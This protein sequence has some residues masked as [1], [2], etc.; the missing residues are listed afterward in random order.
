MY[1]HALRV[2]LPGGRIFACLPDWDAKHAVGVL[3]EVMMDGTAFPA[4]VGEEET[5]PAST[6]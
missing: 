4:R 3:P 5:C 6:D 1:L 2:I